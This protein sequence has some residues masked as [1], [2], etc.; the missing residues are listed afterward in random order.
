M[1][2]AIGDGMVVNCGCGAKEKDSE[3]STS[4]LRIFTIIS[5]G[6]L[7]VIQL[8]RIFL[9]WHKHSIH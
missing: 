7:R 5:S 1:K 4:A 9:S 2:E 8:Y 3:F 6:W